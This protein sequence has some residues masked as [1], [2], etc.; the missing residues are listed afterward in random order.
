MQNIKKVV[1]ACGGF[2][3]TEHIGKVF[4]LM[5]AFPNPCGAEE[6]QT[7]NPPDSSFR[8]S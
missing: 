3:K 1:E 7:S 8:S 2:V 6:G 4:A 5:A